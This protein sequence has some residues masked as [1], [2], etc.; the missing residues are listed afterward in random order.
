MSS[1]NIQAAE[2][3]REMFAQSSTL[4][5]ACGGSVN[6]A[7]AHVYFGATPKLDDQTAYPR[8]LII[9]G[10]SEDF[11]YHMI[12]GGER[13]QMRPEG[14]LNF[15]GIRNTPSTYIT[16]SDCDY[17]AAET[18]H[19]DFFGGV[20]DDIAA[21]SGWDDN[22]SV[23]DIWMKDFAEVEAKFWQELGRF[24]FCGGVISWGDQSRWRGN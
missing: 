20:L 9:I 18:D 8:P 4:Q 5:S 19:M 21:I 24:Y 22:L 15:F 14:T 11:R 16:G 12:A 3:L 10:L 2:K 17:T 1:V 13:N 6:A 7:A 23:T